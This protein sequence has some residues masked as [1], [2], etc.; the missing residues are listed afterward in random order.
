MTDMDLNRQSSVAVFHGSDHK[1]G[2]TMLAQSVC[3]DI[4]RRYPDRSVM[5]LG[6]NSRPSCE[7]VKEDVFSIEDIKLHLDNRTLTAEEIK[8]MCSVRKNLYMLAGI[9]NF[10]E[11]RDFFP[12]TAEYLIM[13]IAQS[14]DIVICDAG[15]D[16][17]N[18][19]ALGALRCG[20]QRYCV[21][22]QQ[23]SSVREFEDKK[24]IFEKLNM[25]FDSIVVN[26]YF[27]KDPYD[28]VYLSERLGIDSEK[29]TTVRM[30]GYGRQAEMDRQ[31]LLE[32]RNEAF[33]S[34]IAALSSLIMEKAGIVMKSERKRRLWITDFI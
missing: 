22:S 11:E 1:T 31:T 17:D 27:N 30:A 29:F 21:I 18:G 26:K 15:N 5:F 32:Y 9:K 10:M 34:D 19:L 3:A 33:G 14:F 6:M 16:L 4:C 20:G 8:A 23:E 13:T 24:W 2:V 12:E 25:K 28:T 7:Y